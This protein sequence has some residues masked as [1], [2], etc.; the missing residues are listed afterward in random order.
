VRPV[1]TRR[2][3]GASSAARPRAGAPHDP[4]HRPAPAPSWWRLCCAP[5]VGPA[6]GGGRT[7]LAVDI[8]ERHRAGQ[9][10]RRY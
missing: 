8:R 10:V 4:S 5:K 2:S 1:R 9:L 6:A 7:L 3:Q